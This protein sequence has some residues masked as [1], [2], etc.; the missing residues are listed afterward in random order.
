MVSRRNKVGI[1]NSGGVL[2]GTVIWIGMLAL[3][4][5]D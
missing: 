3:T 1:G 5:P 2:Y 4:D